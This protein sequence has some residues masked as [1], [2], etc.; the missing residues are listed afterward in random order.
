MKF[1]KE[2]YRKQFLDSPI[3]LQIIVNDAD[4]YSQRVFGKELTVTRVLDAVNGESGV[5]NDHRA[6]DCRDDYTLG[7]DS[8]TGELIRESVFSDQEASQIVAYINRKYGRNDGYKSA[9]HHKFTDPETG[10]PGLPHFHFQIAVSTKA[11]MR[12][13]S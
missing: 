4:Q 10:K 13:Q 1:K 9:I 12:K 11:Y 3:L 7:V 5:H 8:E 2:S 6:V